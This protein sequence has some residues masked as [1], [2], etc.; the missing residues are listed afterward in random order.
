MAS[1]Q[2]LI[3]MQPTPFCN[4]DCGYC[5]LPNRSSN[6]KMDLDVA[7][8]IIMEVFSSKLVSPPIELL[9]HLGEP[10][11]IPISFYE[12]V[13]S[14]IS[15]ISEGTGIAYSLNFQTN[16]MLI[17]D[18][19]IN[20]I[21]KHKINLGISIDGPEFIH[22]RKRVD[23]KSKGTHAQVM[24]GTKMLQESGVPFSVIMVVTKYSLDYPDEICDFFIENKIE[25]IGFNIDEMEGINNSTSFSEVVESKYNK[26][27][28][29]LLERS[30]ASSGK[31]RIREFWQ[32]LRPFTTEISEAV[33]T[34]NV[35]F[36]IFNFD[37]YGNYSTYCPELIAAKSIE[38]NNFNMG[39]ILTDGLDAI[40]TNSV[41][42][43]I[44]DEV[45]K[46][47]EN[48]KKSCEYWS[49]CGGGAPSNKFFENGSFN[50]TETLAC[51]FHKKGVIDVLAHHFEQHFSA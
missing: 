50:T 30:V 35:P 36:R 39:N 33:N 25:D 20:L 8:K 27:I 41:F 12:Q 51:K 42:L 5:Y 24:K 26:F 18:N 45:E 21:K 34:T 31:L 40:Q 11:A 10:L 29:R 9:W 23:R 16:A 22:D 17:N 1:V 15:Q 13:F 37:C 14:I 47:V 48:C 3:V 6:H 46:G 49:F 43:K 32:N 44:K 7:G 19:W 4:I 38:Y 28:T 2:T